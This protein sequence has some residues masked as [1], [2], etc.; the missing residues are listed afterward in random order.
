[1]QSIH[2]HSWHHCSSPFFFTHNVNQSSLTDRDGKS[3]RIQSGMSH[4]LC[5]HTILHGCLVRDGKSQRIQSGMSHS[6]CKHTILHGCLLRT[7]LAVS[8]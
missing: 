3:Q 2:V 4:S 6:L 5:K 1:M 7:A 8:Y